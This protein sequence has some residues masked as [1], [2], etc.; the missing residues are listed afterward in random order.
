MKDY[1]FIDSRDPFTFADHSRFC[2]L[3]LGLADSGHRVAVYLVENGVLPARAGG[4]AD[5]LDALIERRI[6]VLADDFSLRERGIGHERLREGVQPA[7][8]DAVIE[9]MAGGDTVIW[10]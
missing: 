1:L 8:I 2:D 7:E 9:C 3:V 5:G 10:H 4:R 6:P